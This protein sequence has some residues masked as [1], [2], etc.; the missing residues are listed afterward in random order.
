MISVAALAA[1]AETGA[2][3]ESCVVLINELVASFG[4]PMLHH[5]RLGVHSLLRGIWNISEVTDMVHMFYGMTAFNQRLDK[6][7]VRLV[8]GVCFM[9]CCNHS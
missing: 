7:D 9:L 2:R 6:W 4:P 8:T 1:M 5:E 3:T